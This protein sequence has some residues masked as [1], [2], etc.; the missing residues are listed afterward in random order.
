MPRRVLGV[1]TFLLLTGLSVPLHI[2]A[3]FFVYVQ[4]ESPGDTASA[5]PLL[6]GMFAAVFLALLATGLLT[7][8]VG[9]FPGRWRAR[10]TFSFLSGVIALAIAY[11]AAITQFR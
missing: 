9:G 4:I 3:V 8:L 1:A 11:G 2:L 6:A 10:V 5:V 7:Q